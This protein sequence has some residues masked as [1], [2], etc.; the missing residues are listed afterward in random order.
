M[1]RPVRLLPREQRGPGARHIRALRSDPTPDEA[2]GGYQAETGTVLILSGS[3]GAGHDGAADELTRRLR[4]EGITVRQRDYLDALPRFSQRMLR[5]G[6]SISV[7]YVPAFF[8]WLFASIEH[9]GWV[10]WLAI[11]FCDTAN[12]RVRGWVSADVAVVVSTYPLA[13]QCLGRLKQTGRISQPVLTYLTDPAVHRLWVHPGVEQHLTVT[14]ATAEQ[15]RTQY[16]VAMRAVGALV[17]PGFSAALSA[18]QRSSVRAR[19]GVG[20]GEPLALVVS[21]SLGLGEVPASVRAVQA[22]GIYRV[23]V[24][25]GRNHRLRHEMAQLPGVLALGWRDDVAALMGAADVLVHNAG[26]LSLTEA[27]TAGL[28]A[29][30]YRPL[31]GHGRANAALL[32]RAGLAPWPQTLE[33]LRGALAEALQRGGSG[34]TALIHSPDAAE[35][36]IARLRQARA[37]SVPLPRPRMGRRST[38]AE[39]RL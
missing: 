20:D 4:V 26:G 17:P 19:L 24:L 39:N 18:D 3:V 28:A 21:G 8:Q 38:A 36:V 27:M 9:R 14:A 23:A 31:P 35:M 5:D 2:R 32:A 15:G 1:G 7:G 25:C 6:Y 16:G 34:R 30:T 10:Q 11:T 13:S 22:A 29:V 37:A 12:R 33:D